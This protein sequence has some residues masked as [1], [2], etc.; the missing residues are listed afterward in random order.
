MAGLALALFVLYLALAVGARLLHVVDRWGLYADDPLHALYV[1][2]GGWPS[3]PWRPTYT[4]GATSGSKNR[5]GTLRGTV[6]GEDAGAP[7]GCEAG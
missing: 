5:D 1:W 4:S 7:R 3:W 2:E 6:P